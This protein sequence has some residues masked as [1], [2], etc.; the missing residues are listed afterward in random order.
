MVHLHLNIMLNMVETKI[1][2]INQT[3]YAR[4]PAA[5]ARRLGLSEGEV[6]DIEVKPRRKT[7]SG[8]MALFGKRKGLA[9]P[10]DA[11]LWGEHGA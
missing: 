10:S 11:E 5:E 6:V 1:V 2:R 3:L 9:L 4:V 8:A 7:A